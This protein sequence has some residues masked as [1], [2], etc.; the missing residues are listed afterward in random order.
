M[1]STCFRVSYDKKSKVDAVVDCSKDNGSLVQ[2]D[3]EVKHLAV[4]QFIQTETMPGKLYQPTGKS[5]L[6]YLIKWEKKC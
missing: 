5:R 3:S 4:T 6:L 1:S 2:I